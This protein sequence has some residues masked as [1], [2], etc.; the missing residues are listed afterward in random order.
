[1]PICSVF[2]ETRSV[3]TSLRFTSL[4]FFITTFAK[5][6]MWKSNTLGY[7]AW[8]H[9]AHILLWNKQLTNFNNVIIFKIIINKFAK[10]RSQKLTMSSFFQWLDGLLFVFEVFFEVFFECLL[11]FYFSNSIISRTERA[12]FT[13]SFSCRFSVGEKCSFPIRRISRFNRKYFS[14]LRQWMSLI[15]R[16][17]ILQCWAGTWTQC[18]SSLVVSLVSWYYSGHWIAATLWSVK[19]DT[20]YVSLHIGGRITDCTASVYP[21]LLCLSQLQNGN[22]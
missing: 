18:S 1:M 12:N 8:W 11:W 15:S 3:N 5:T 4:K 16:A 2:S 17:E 13:S 6:I 20:Y 22:K 9:S 19:A 14:R 7:M 21:S 10:C